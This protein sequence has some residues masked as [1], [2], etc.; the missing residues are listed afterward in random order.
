MFAL[1]PI[2]ALQYQSKDQNRK[3][4]ID[5]IKG[6]LKEGLQNSLTLVD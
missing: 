5:P 4:E 3:V 2:K 6:L 1:W